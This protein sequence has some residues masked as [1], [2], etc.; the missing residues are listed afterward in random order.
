MRRF[1][2]AAAAIAEQRP[3]HAK[4]AILASYLKTLDDADLEAATRF[5]TGNPLATR[6]ARSLGLGSRTIAAVAQCFWGFTPEELSARYRD[7][8]DLGA[9]L[10]PLARSA[11]DLGLLARQTLSPASLYA[12]FGQIASA[13]GKGAGK[14][15]EAVLEEIL[16]SCQDSLDSCYVIKIITG[17]LRIG[18]REG[19]VYDAIAT[20]FETTRQV[21][22]R[23]AMASGDLGAVAVAAKHGQLE[24][25]HIA[26]ESPFGFML[27]SP[28]PFGEAYTDLAKHRWMVE[29][30]YD[31]IRVQAHVCKRRVILFS[32][33][34]NDVSH[35]YPEI[36]KA[37]RGQPHPMILDGEIVASRGGRTLP[38][39]ILQARLSRKEID[40]A[41]LRDIPLVY[42]VFDAIAIDDAFVIDEPFER[43]RRLLDLTFEPVERALLA[44]IECLEI[45]PGANVVNTRFDDA[46]ARGNEGI[47]L[48]RADAPYQLGRRGRSWLKLKRELATLDVVVVAVEWGHGKRSKV[49]SDYTFAVLAEDGSLPA[50]GKAYSGLTDAEISE[51]TPWFLE[52]ALSPDARRIKARASEIPVTP[53]IVIEVAFD[54]IQ[55]S[56]LHESGFSLRFPRIVRVRHDKPASEIDTMRRVREIY[57]EMLVRESFA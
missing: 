3:N 37:L 54:I 39:R 40:P 44:P 21:I 56:E 16:R 5:F 55:A 49:L 12:L 32:R 17:D 19:L 47:M 15:R 57:D 26:Y 8:G 51:L 45:N 7:S 41:L 28:I 46:R 1:A 2:E 30:K 11:N 23:A 6:D 52:H 4:I 42:I 31:G 13:S 18:L 35:S 34:L 38:F 9:A 43:R 48:K 20:A 22:A 10:G 25:I 50:I 33:T 24:S 27:A 36:C 53:K 29:D 14:K